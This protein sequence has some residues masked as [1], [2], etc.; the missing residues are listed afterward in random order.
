MRKIAIY[1]FLTVCSAY[2]SSCDTIIEVYASN[3][4]VTKYYDSEWNL[5]Y[6]KREAKFFRATSAKFVAIVWLL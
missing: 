4:W 5:T 1:V 6:N 3:G 2:F